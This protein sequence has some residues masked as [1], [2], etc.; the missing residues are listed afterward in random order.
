MFLHYGVVRPLGCIAIINLH[1]D[2]NHTP[3]PKPHS[4]LSNFGKCE[5]RKASDP[6]ATCRCCDE[7]FAVES[8]GRCL[9][10]QEER[11]AR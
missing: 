10:P 8:W 2:R 5:L 11:E 3:N 9:F 1:Q 7:D 4:V 6:D